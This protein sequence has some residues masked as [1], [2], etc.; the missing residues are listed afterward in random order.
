MAITPQLQNA[1][2]P[3]DP[4][5]ELLPVSN[6]ALSSYALVVASN[7][8]FRVS[9]DPGGKRGGVQVK[10]S[11]APGPARRSISRVS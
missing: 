6:V 9:A 2:L 1:N 11:P 3:L 10:F 8:R 7:S 4:G 5:V